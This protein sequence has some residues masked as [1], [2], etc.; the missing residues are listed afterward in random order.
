MRNLITDVPG[1]LVGNAQDVRA[2]TGVTVA[3]F[4]QGVV[5]S[6]A[7]LGGA[8]GSR[9][10]TLLEPEMT[11]GVVD[12]VVLSGGSLYGLDAA[13]G[14]TSVLCAQGKGGTFGGITL[15]V[16]VQA[17]LFDLINGGEKSWLNEPLTIRPPYW[18]LGRE[19]ARAASQDFALGTV[20]A[21]YGATTVNL[22]GGLGSASTVTGRGFVVGALAAVNAIGSAT[23]GDSPYFWAGAY[24]QA[25]EF[26]GRGWPS[27]V[28]T[29]ALQ[30]RF[31]GQ[32]APVAATTIA[33][34]ATDAKLTKS[35]CKRL[36]IMAND[37]LARALRPVHAPNDGDTVFAAATGGAAE[38]LGPAGEPPA[39]TELG[40]AAADCLARAVARG[41]YE[42]TALPYRNAV[43]DFRQRFG[44]R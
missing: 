18:D 39:L 22:K 21:G 9:A 3:V 4:E 30:L 13:G 2:A 17:I 29:E 40:A 35:E 33:L 20:G 23:I 5:A 15:P 43:P 38:S 41:V 1:V 42:A 32:P 31:K 37:G 27:Q 19:A 6:V 25:G 28:P 16:A 7:T 34:V 8:P 10:V 26:G 24:E 36:A 12:A 14:V 44:G 11:R